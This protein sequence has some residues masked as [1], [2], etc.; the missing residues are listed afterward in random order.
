MQVKIA[1]S[2]SLIQLSRL[3]MVV[4]HEKPDTIYHTVLIDMFSLPVID[5][6]PLHKA[7]LVLYE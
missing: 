6:N 4:N 5:D 1:E 3:A 2:Y 7:T